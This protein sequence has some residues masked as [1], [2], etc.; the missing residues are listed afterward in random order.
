[1]LRL[2]L[3]ARGHT[4]P[5]EPTLNR[6]ACHPERA[7]K[8]A[9]P[10]RLAAM[11]HGDRYRLDAVKSTYREAAG[12]FAHAGGSIDR[13]DWYHTIMDRQ[14]VTVLGHIRRIATAHDRRP[15]AVH[16]DCLWYASGLPDWREAAAE[17][18]IRIGHDLGTFRHHSTARAA[19]YFK[20]K[21]A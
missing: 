20:P 10:A 3:H 12:L 5:A 6:R 14:R 17:L 9:H 8:L 19:D 2:R 4:R 15:L 11:A 18:G 21:G 13:A 16:T 7:G 1:M